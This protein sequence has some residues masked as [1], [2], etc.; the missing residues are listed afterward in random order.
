MR[1]ALMTVSDRPHAWGDTPDAMQRNAAL[2]LLDGGGCTRPNQ[3]HKS[4]PAGLPVA[5]ITL[6]QARAGGPVFIEM[7]GR[8]GKNL[9]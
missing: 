9:P 7:Q 5:P 1:T 4:P 2:P 8:V 6:Q 3:A